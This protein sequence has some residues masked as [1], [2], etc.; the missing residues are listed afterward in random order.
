MSRRSFIHLDDVSDATLKVMLHGR[1]GD[2]YHISTNEV[3]SIRELVEKICSKLGV[4]FEDHAE[5]VGERLGK[6]AAYQLDSTKL[7][8]ELGWMDKVSLD[9][10]L[11]QCI[12]WVKE[13]LEV[14]KNQPFDYSHKP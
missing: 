7:R 13:N 1:N 8:R 11:D 2:S 3:I 12:D 5:V 10:G 6:D 9:Q 4:Q 14:L